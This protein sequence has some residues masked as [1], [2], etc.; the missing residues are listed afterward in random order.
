MSLDIKPSE[1]STEVEKIP[2]V[3]LSADDALLQAQGHKAELD[4]SFSWIG[5]IGFAFRYCC[6]WIL[7]VKLI[8]IVFQTHGWGMLPLSGQSSFMEEVR[9][10]YLGPSFRL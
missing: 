10:L 1:Q 9:R 6:P 4:R 3:S 2:D 5:A 7:R 8:V